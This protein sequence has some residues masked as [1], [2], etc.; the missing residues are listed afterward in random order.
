[1]SQMLPDLVPPGGSPVTARAR[2]SKPRGMFSRD[3]SAECSLR[4]V[5][6]SSVIFAQLTGI[7]VFGASGAIGAVGGMYLAI[8]LFLDHIL[9]AVVG[10]CHERLHLKQLGMGNVSDGTLDG[11]LEPVQVSFNLVEGVWRRH[12]LWAMKMRGLWN[13]CAEESFCGRHM[14]SVQGQCRRY[15]VGRVIVQLEIRVN[16]GQS[17][18][19]GKDICTGAAR[20]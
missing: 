3:V 13:T 20:W 9:K 11:R 5:R 16:F 19:S 17:S 15:V 12:A 8:N 14:S 10:V 18:T 1:M 4:G 6:S 7:P 2:M